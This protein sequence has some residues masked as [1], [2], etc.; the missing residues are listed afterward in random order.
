MKRFFMILALL[1]VP[2]LEA[3]VTCTASVAPTICKQFDAEFGGDASMWPL[4]GWTKRI[5]IVIVDPTQFKAE[6]AKLDAD[7]DAAVKSAKTVGDTNRIGSR[8]A[9]RGVFG[10][11]VILECPKSNIVQRIVISTEAIARS[12]LNPSISDLSNELFFYV[13]GYDDGF[14]QSGANQ[15]P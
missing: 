12:A 10:N 5:E 14:M 7:R 11:D 9:G 2:T 4:G 13:V 6:R 15:V 1:S 8:E 3:Q